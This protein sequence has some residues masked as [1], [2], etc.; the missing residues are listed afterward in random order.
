M[1]MVKEAT[2]IWNTGLCI[3]EID[4]AHHPIMN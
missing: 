2:G 4:I 3:A 1:S